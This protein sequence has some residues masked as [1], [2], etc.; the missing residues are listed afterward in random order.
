MCLF[1][2][3]NQHAAT[4]SDRCVT[5]IPSTGTEAT[6]RRQR[7]CLPSAF[8]FISQ[9]SAEREMFIQKLGVKKER[10]EMETLNW[11]TVDIG[12]I[13]FKLIIKEN[14][15]RLEMEYHCE[16]YCRDGGGGGGEGG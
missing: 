2:K 4:T 12:E 9:I 3:F 6:L 11:I 5:P 14:N 7:T 1:H 16:C 8:Q 13:S 10:G 15:D